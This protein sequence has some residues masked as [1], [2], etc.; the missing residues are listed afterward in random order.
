MFADLPF[1]GTLD[2][3]AIFSRFDDETNPPNV[4]TWEAS[5]VDVVFKAAT[6]P[7]NL[8]TT[9]SKSPEAV[10]C[11]GLFSRTGFYLEGVRREAGR[12]CTARKAIG[13]IQHTH[14]QIFCVPVFQSLGAVQPGFNVSRA[15]A[16]AQHYH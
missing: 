4:T 13:R 1:Q 14:I 2:L 12:D 6:P 10:S 16:R 5:S 7:K 15:H 9:N 8:K 3:D 11:L